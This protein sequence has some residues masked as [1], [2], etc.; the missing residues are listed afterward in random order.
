MLFIYLADRRPMNTKVNYLMFL[1]RLMPF[2]LLTV[3][4]ML[5]LAGK[6]FDDDYQAKKRK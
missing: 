1:E 5:R 2:W 4:P 3:D 6:T